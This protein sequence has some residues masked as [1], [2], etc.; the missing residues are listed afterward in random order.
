MVFDS[1]T[2]AAQT[3][4]VYAHFRADAAHETSYG[5]GSSWKI[6]KGSNLYLLQ[7]DKRVPH[8]LKDNRPGGNMH[9]RIPKS[10]RI[11]GSS[12]SNTMLDFLNRSIQLF[13]STF[14]CQPS[15]KRTNLACLL[16]RSYSALGIG[17]SQLASAV[18]PPL[19]YAPKADAS[20][21]DLHAKRKDPCANATA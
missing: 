8:D 9:F 3:L 5:S 21:H 18:A 6:Q 20:V 7:G 12:E 13:A 17:C 16:N 11:R 19:H 15:W 1:S 4:I 2:S 10:C 14:T